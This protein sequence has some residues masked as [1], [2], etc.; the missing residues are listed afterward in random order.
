MTDNSTYVIKSTS[1]AFRTNGSDQAGYGRDAV[2]YRRGG[3]ATQQGT[4]D[5]YFTRESSNYE[6]SF[7][8]SGN[9]VLIQVTGRVGHT[10]NWK[11]C[12]STVEV[13]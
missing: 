11:T 5:T 6:V 3:G 12:Y 7:A 4:T 10:I 8:T 13:S 2:F 9:D 1:A